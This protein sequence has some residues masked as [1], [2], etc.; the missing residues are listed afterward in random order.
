MPPPTGT[1]AGGRRTGWRQD[2]FTPTQEAR[3][4]ET[5][6]VKRPDPG[7]LL[8][9]TDLHQSVAHF[10]AGQGETAQFPTAFAAEDQA[11]VIVQLRRV[12]VPSWG[13][14]EDKSC[15]TSS[16]RSASRMEAY[17]PVREPKYAA[18]EWA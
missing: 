8:P 10:P 16:T 3:G 4:Q 15:R 11:G 12:Q 17:R 2:I 7:I 13:L 5:V 14:L 18:K 9:V 6:A 1:R